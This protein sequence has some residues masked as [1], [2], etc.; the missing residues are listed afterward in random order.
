M[1]AGA[2]IKLFGSKEELLIA[3]LEHWAV[4]AR[5]VIGEQNHGLAQL[6]GFGRLMRFHMEHRGFLELY[7]TMA[8]EAAAGQG[9]PA[10]SFI[11]R[12][13]STTL[14]DLRRL[15]AE[16]VAQGAFRPM[17]DGEISNEAEA[18]LAVMDGLEIQLLLKPDFDLERSFRMY[19]G[20]LEAR[21]APVLDEPRW[22][23]ADST[24]V[25]SIPV[26]P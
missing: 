26:N 8:A 6:E 13:Y 11:E 9:H 18:L 7:I 15:F 12:R 4:L 24:G 5:D 21:L 14:A 16:G 20:N 22:R 23:T 3:V 25:Q 1:T 2:I 19:V 10:H 17:L